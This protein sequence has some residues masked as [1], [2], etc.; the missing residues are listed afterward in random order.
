MEMGL[1]ILKCGDI[2]VSLWL[3]TTED[4]PTKEWDLALEHLT[5]LRR[6]RGGDLTKI[7]ALAITDGGA[8]NVTQRAHLFTNLY[9]GKAKSAVVTTALSNRIKRGVVT[10]ISW[11]NPSFKAFQPEEYKLALAHLDL[12]DHWPM[13]WSELINLQKALPVNQT[14]RLMGEQARKTS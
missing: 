14:L 8:P 9:E 10:A 1:A 13:L 3:H 2:D 12:G 4:P 7:R 5:T 11:I 6:Q